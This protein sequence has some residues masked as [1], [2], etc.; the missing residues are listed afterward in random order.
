MEWC[1]MIRWHSTHYKLIIQNPNISYK[2]LAKLLGIHI[3]SVIKMSKELGVRHF[4]CSFNCGFRY[5]F[6]C[7]SRCVYKVFAR[8]REIGESGNFEKAVEILDKYLFEVEQ[9]FIKL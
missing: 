6:F 9:G 1:I 8:K 2:A 7:P 3:N 5:L 4:G